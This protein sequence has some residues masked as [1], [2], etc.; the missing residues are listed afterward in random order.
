MPSDSFSSPE[1]E[2]TEGR[3][4]ASLDQNGYHCVW[5]IAAT[6]GEIIALNIT[7]VDIGHS[8]DCQEDYLE[9]RDGYWH[10]SPLLGT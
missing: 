7:D 5:R 10:K 2:Q 3:F 4:P 1:F 8:K 9:I 6:H